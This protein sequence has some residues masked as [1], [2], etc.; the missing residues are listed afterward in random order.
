MEADCCQLNRISSAAPCLFFYFFLKLLYF[1]FFYCIFQLQL[2]SNEVT[3][4]EITAEFNQPVYGLE[5][6]QTIWAA[7]PTPVDGDNSKWKFTPVE[8]DDHLNGPSFEFN[9]LGRTNSGG[10]NANM[11]T[12]CSPDNVGGDGQQVPLILSNPNS[13]T[14]ILYTNFKH[15]SFNPH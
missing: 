3:N 12:L 7:H 9:F 13:S 15:I 2:P 10:V 6:G 11:V 4:W 1:K 8:W 5:L 14:Q